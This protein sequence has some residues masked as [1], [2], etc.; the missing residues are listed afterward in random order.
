VVTERTDEWYDPAVVRGYFDDR[1]VSVFVAG[2][3]VVGYAFCRHYPAENRLHLTAI[4]VRPERWGEGI[5][6]RLLERVEAEAQTLDVER[7]DLVVLAA[8]D[9]GRS[10]YDRHDYEQV[11]ER[12]ETL[13]EARELVYEK[14]L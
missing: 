12:E 11:H 4:Y 2:D 13:D 8:N 7:V 3:P 6:S 5:G 1:E 9:I 10:F 14:S